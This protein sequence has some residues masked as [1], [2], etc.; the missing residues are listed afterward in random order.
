[1]A[2]LD[3]PAEL[4]VGG[5]VVLVQRLQPGD[6]LLHL[7]E[8]RELRLFGLLLIGLLRLVGVEL[9]FR[10][11]PLG[12]QDGS[13][14][15]CTYLCLQHVRGA[16]VADGD[17]RRALERLRELGVHLDQQVPLL[18]HLPVAG[19]DALGAPVDERLADD[20][21]ADVDH[22]GA[23]QLDELVALRRHVVVHGLELREEVEDLLHGEVRVLRHGQVADGVRGDDCNGQNEIG[24]LTLFGALDDVLQVVDGHR[25][26]GRQVHLGIDGE[27][28]VDL[29]LVS[30]LR[31]ERRHVHELGLHLVGK[32]FDL[33]Y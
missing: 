14:N 23:R 22:P 15:S 26:E 9:R 30:E 6:L 25:L 27:E 1:M 13:V 17:G 10:A 3:Q 31:G 8:L 21:R 11:P 5:R 7:G 2:A 16:A 32:I 33:F 12:L 18:R 20:G 4:V 19:D 28:R 24:V 29:T